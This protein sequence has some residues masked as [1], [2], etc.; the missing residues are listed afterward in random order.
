MVGRRA[1]VSNGTLEAGLTCPANSYWGSGFTSL[2]Y[3]LGRSWMKQRNSSFEM[4]TLKIRQL[5]KK[6][7]QGLPA[8]LTTL[9]RSIVPL[10]ITLSMSLF[11]S[12]M[13][14]VIVDEKEKRI[15]EILKMV[16]L[17]DSVFWLSW[18]IVY[19]SL[20]FITSLLGS[21]LISSLVLTSRTF[22]LITF[23]LML[24]FGLTIIMFAFLLTAL[25]SKAKT[26]AKVGGLSTMAFS[27][28][29]YIQVKVMSK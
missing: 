27:M 1:M 11:I 16:G 28:L 14:T 7:Y 23:I 5:P 13:L 29:Y 17:R 12:P 18:F 22:F 2:Q 6:A 8:A 25:F 3:L 21:L 26:A 19:A 9:F 4:P 15:K 24:Q 20:I 10:Y